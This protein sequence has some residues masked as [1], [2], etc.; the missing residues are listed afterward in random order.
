MPG[1]AWASPAVRDDAHCHRTL[2]SQNDH[3][4]RR[5]NDMAISKARVVQ[6]SAAVLLVAALVATMAVTGRGLQRTLVMAT[7]PAGSAYALYGERYRALLAK[8][9]VE[10]RLQP[11]G[12]TLENL[13]L[14]NDPAAG[15]DVAFVSAGTTSPEKSPDLRALGTVFLEE[16]WFFS[17]DPGLAGGDLAALRG[18]RMSI[19]T[20]GSATRAIA[21]V[22][23]RLN[24][25]DPAAAEFV[26]LS[27][28]EAAEQLRR[29]DI[30]AAMIMTSADSPLVREMLADPAIHLVSFR[31]AAAY[32]ARY[33]FLMQLTVPEGV[34]DLALNRPPA[35][36]T[37]FGT[38]VSLAV[39]EDVPPA[40]Q[41]L[42]L[43]TAARVHAGPGMFIKAGQ[44]PAAQAIDLPL[45]APATQYYKSGLPFLQRYLPFWVAVL[46]GRLLYFLIPIV[47]VLY[48]LLRVAPGLYGWAMRRRIYRLYGELKFLE[49]ELD[50]GAG[51][52]AGSRLRDQLEQLERRV[53]RMH[54]PLAYANQ[55]YTLRLH[56]NLVRSRLAQPEALRP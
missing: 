48:P 35:D 19:G 32:V 56:I 7:G 3:I 40:L 2:D 16:V 34:G 29:G 33:P 26:G 21:E 30:D 38:S 51:S 8:Q 11:S 31:R 12:G 49:H 20:E 1:E 6:I 23:I 41:A 46:V 4:G 14:L 50:G 10:L 24:A 27:P 53:E 44:F 17:R 18:K 37:T 13:R 28:Q 47:G 15:I 36:V 25:V 39:R 55:V 43:D 5:M 54:V 9:G 45:S 42:L 52:E 22:L